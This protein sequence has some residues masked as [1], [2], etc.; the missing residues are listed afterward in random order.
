[1]A[2]VPNAKIIERYKDLLANRTHDVIL[3]DEALNMLETELAREREA[4]SKV[5]EEN[6]SLTRAL[7]R[8]NDLIKDL[9]GQNKTSP[10]IQ[11]EVVSEG[12]GY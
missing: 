1:M 2:E 7:G 4:H 9:R 11:G 3:R 10:V 8:A 12:D 5:K 6:E